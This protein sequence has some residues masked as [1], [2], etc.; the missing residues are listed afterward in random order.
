MAIEEELMREKEADSNLQRQIDDEDYKKHCLEREIKRKAKIKQLERQTT[1]MSSRIK[2]ISQQ[3]MVQ[4]KSSRESLL[5]KIQAMQRA[6]ERRRRDAKRKVTTI[7]SSMAQSLLKENKIGNYTICFPNRTK[8]EREGYCRENFHVDDPE[9]ESDCLLSNIDYCS[10]C[11]ENEFGSN[12]DELRTKCYN[13]CDEEDAKPD[14]VCI[15]IPNENRIDADYQQDAMFGGMNDDHYRQDHRRYVDNDDEEGNDNNY[16]NG[17]NE[18]EDNVDNEDFNDLR[19][20]YDYRGYNHDENDDDDSEYEEGE[21]EQETNSH[22]LGHIKNLND[23]YIEDDSDYKQRTHLGNYDHQQQRSNVPYMRKNKGMKDNYSNKNSIKNSY[24]DRNNKFFND[25]RS[26]DYNSNKNFGM[27]D[28]QLRKQIVNKILNGK[29]P[30]TQNLQSLRPQ[31]IN[32]SNNLS[33][34]LLTHTKKLND[35][36]NRKNILNL[37]VQNEAKQGVKVGVTGSVTAN[38][39]TVQKNYRTESERNL[40]FERQQILKNQEIARKTNI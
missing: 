32:N 17:E 10:V 29:N 14:E 34:A 3:A 1:D 22:H 21:D 12:Q 28:D 31:N 40:S 25:K 9:K 19:K 27:N 20:K 23:E 8:H 33:N 13:M 24:K 39:Q 11:C 15:K 4:V 30:Q 37:Q 35:L 38:N 7:R 36:N 26:F 2:R 16:H 5:Q 18:N 6:A